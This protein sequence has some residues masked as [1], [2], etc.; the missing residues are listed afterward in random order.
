MSFDWKNLVGTVAPTL[1]TV[2][3]GGNPL[4]GMAVKAIAE[5][6][7]LPAS[8]GEKD[9][10]AA[11]ASAT[12]E[13]LLKL[14]EANFAFEQRMEELGVDLERIAADDRASA[15]NMQSNTKAWIV[16]VLGGVTVAGFFAVVGWVLSGKVSLEST[17]LGFVLGQVSAK[18]EQVYNFYFGSSAGSKEK[19]QH[20]ANIKG[21]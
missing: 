19:T 10:E 13:T 21:G 15:R 18:A 11:L 1:A 7:G 6:L 5:S 2:L 4:A 17:L 3:S 8:S 14:K 12:P 16:P 9:V 20:M